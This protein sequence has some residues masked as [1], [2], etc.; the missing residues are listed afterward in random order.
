MKIFVV[1]GHNRNLNNTSAYAAFSTREAA[2]R[3]AKSDE[4]YLADIWAINEVEVN[5]ELNAEAPATR[6]TSSGTERS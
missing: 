4:N 1:I 2:E 5:V 6:T 3:W